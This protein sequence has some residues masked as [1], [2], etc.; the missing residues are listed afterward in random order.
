MTWFKL[1]VSGQ[2]EADLDRL[3]RIAA[4]LP[5]GAQVTLDGNEQYA[6]PTDLADVLDELERRGAADE[7]L[8][9]LISIEQPVSRKQTFEPITQHG[10]SRLGERAPVIIDEADATIDAFPKA[11]ALGYRGVSMKACKG[12]LRALIN[13]ARID[14]DGDGFQSAEDLT[15]LPHLPLC[16]DLAVV[17]AL[18]LPHVERNGHHYF[19]CGAHLG[20][21]ERHDLAA[22]HSSLLRDGT[23]LHIEGGSIDLSSV[24]SAPGFGYAGPVGAPALE[25][26]APSPR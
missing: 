7:L 18:G 3:E 24:N 1:K 10:I 11:R 15:N 19:R 23:D 9:G 25:L 26:P 21:E 13:R 16:Q 14:A 2:R 5:R 8:R 17:G 20:E 22:H 6:R 4:L 12:V